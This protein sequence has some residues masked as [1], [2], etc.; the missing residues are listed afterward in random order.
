MQRGRLHDE[1]SLRSRPRPQL[2]HRQYTPHEA[3]TRTHLSDQ[4]PQFQEATH[5]FKRDECLN[6]LHNES[7][8]G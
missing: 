6:L 2:R 5:G 4:Q 7:E 1:R 3:K 8:E